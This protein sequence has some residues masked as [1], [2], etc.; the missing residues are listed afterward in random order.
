MSVTIKIYDREFN[1]A[2]E[3]GMVDGLKAGTVFYHAR[4]QQAVNTS[5]QRGT[6]PSQP[7][8]PP[9]KRTGF[10]QQNIVYE[11]DEDQFRSRMGVTKNGI[12]MFWLE[13]GTRPKRIRPK[14]G[15][16]FLMI[17]W[18]PPDGSTRAPTQKEI[19]NI[20][21]KKIK[22]KWFYFRPEVMRP[23]I[24]RRPW[25]LVTLRKHRETITRLLTSKF[26]KR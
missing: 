24:K 1:K 4:A 11:I 25:M 23:G 18:R 17:P 26:P 21:L 3:R 15:K 9:R 20:G 16:R 2:V 8:E 7:G 13:V 22:G 12:Y 5:N 19:D 14:N 6:K 10:G